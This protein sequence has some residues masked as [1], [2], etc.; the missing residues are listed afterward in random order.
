MTRNAPAKMEK[1]QKVFAIK[2]LWC[3]I[4]PFYISVLRLASAPDK[5]ARGF[6]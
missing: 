5:G 4:H 2:V 6:V 1:S 3:I